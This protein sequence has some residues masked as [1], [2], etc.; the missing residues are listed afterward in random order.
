MTS[1]RSVNGSGWSS[2]IVL[3]PD[4]TPENLSKSG[5]DAVFAA[6]NGAECLTLIHRVIPGPSAGGND[7]IIKPFDQAKLLER[8]RH[9]T[10]RS[11]GSAAAQE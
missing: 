7:F 3:G 11:V 4:D 6:K 9:W 1:T 5:D 8:T 10:G 2:K